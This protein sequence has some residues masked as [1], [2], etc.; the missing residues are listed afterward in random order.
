MYLVGSR[1]WVDLSGGCADR[2]PPGAPGSSA[3]LV[4]QHLD[5]GRVPL[6]GHVRV[7]G[8]LHQDS[9]LKQILD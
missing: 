3:P 7:V 2:R 9:V 4:G 5:A 8:G 1:R 6:E